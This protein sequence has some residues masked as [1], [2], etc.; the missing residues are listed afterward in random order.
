[1][2]AGDHRPRAAVLARA[3][4]AA[5]HEREGEADA[6]AGDQRD[7]DHLRE[8]AEVDD[9]RRGGDHR[10]VLSAAAVVVIAA[11]CWKRRTNM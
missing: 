8:L 1:M 2:G 5:D 10:L 6:D 4:R 3:H 11:P 7:L 9:L